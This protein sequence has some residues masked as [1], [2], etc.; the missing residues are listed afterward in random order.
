[1]L[2]TPHLCLWFFG[3]QTASICIVMLEP[4]HFFFYRYFGAKQLLF[5]WFFRSQTTPMFIVILQPIHLYVDDY[6]GAKQPLFLWLFGSQ[7]I[8]MFM[9]IFGPN[10][11]YLFLVKPFF[12]SNHCLRCHHFF[13]GY[14][15]GVRTSCQTTI[16]SMLQNNHKDRNCLAPQ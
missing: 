7:T 14:F 12:G 2:Y 3:A 10:H 8:S 15:L 9:V 16:I 6:V 1:M 5:L 11:F 4:N 13:C